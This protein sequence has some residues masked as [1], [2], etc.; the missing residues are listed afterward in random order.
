[1]LTEEHKA[2]SYCNDKLKLKLNF[3]DLDE[4]ID[5]GKKHNF[6][7][8][9]SSAYIMQGNL[10]YE[11]NLFNNAFLQY[12]DALTVSNALSD[13]DKMYIYN[14]LAKCKLMTLH[15]ED[16]LAYLCKCYS[17][18]V[19]FKDTFVTRSCIF[20][21][22][23]TYKKLGEFDNAILYIDK[24]LD[25]WD[26]H[27][28][29]DK[30]IE[31]IIL[32]ANCYIEKNQHNI[33]IEIYMNTLNKFGDK[34]GSLLGYI[35]HNLGLIYLDIN[36]LVNSLNCFNKA[37]SIKSAFNNINLASSFI[38]KS[39][40][41]MKQNLYH[42]AISLLEKGLT[43][44]EEY[45][46]KEYLLN[47]Y[48]LLEKAYIALGN[49]DKLEEVYLRSLKTLDDIDNCKLLDIYMKLSMLN[50][51]YLNYEKR[52]EFLFKNQSQENIGMV[53]MM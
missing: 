33:A 24:L 8:V 22:A 3:N 50:P 11:E 5:I 47:G 15:Y 31:T 44:A 13:K 28:N 4:I 17:Y 46:D 40:V 36:E 19:Q 39:R 29:F 1:M 12:Y 45:S 18:S 41:Y 38:D 26:F 37:I 7:D 49:D 23:L 20:N 2:R 25:S 30:Y 16:A 35:Y 14:K 9:L 48:K 6:L 21:L 43:L 34:L 52:A 10:L 27:D 51:S 32:K 53:S 42:E